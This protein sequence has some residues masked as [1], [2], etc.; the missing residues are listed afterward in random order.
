MVNFSKEYCFL[1]KEGPSSLQK[2]LLLVQRVRFLVQK[3]I[4]FKQKDSIL[5]QI[6]SF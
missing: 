5:A 2:T 6:T 4:I 1:V 3:A